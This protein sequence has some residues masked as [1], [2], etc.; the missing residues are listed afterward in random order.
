MNEVL[1]VF[2]KYFAD[3]SN[4]VIFYGGKEKVQRLL[5]IIEMG[6]MHPGDAPDMII[7]T[8][9]TILAIEH[10][11]VDCYAS[12]KNGSIHRIEEARINRE[13]EKILPTE[14]GVVIHDSING[15]S[16]Y[17][18]YVKNVE[19]NFRNHYEKIGQYTDNIVKEY[20][21]KEIVVCFLIED[22]SPLGTMVSQNEKIEP[23]VLSCSSEFL[24]LLK[25]CTRVDYV[26]ACSEYENNKYVWVISNQEIDEYIKN[27]RDYANMEFINFEPQVCIFKTLVDLDT[28]KC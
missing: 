10:F 21:D 23:V 19:K 9:N 8:E 2:E 16:S 15:N 27:A 4:E 6:E 7:E 11:E 5:D 18:S 14:T 1:Q 25:S 12:G 26:M 20:A 28:G 24:T 17:E 13:Q 22:V 3:E